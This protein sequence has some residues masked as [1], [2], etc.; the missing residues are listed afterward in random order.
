LK[1]GEIFGLLGPN[2]AG[3]TTLIRIINRIIEPE[4]GEIRYNGEL[5]K[6]KH[7]AEIGYLPEERGL[8][9]S[10]TVYDHAM[11]LGRLRR[12]SK[13]EVNRNLNH[14]LDKFDIASWKN[15]RIEELSKGMAQK[16]QFIC[17]V[18]HE[19]KLLILDEP[20]SG[21]DPV[22]VELIQNELQTMKKAGKTIMLSSH[23]MKSV[24]EICD[25]AALIHQSRKILEGSVQQI[26]EDRKNGRFAIKFKGNM[27]AFAN[28][29][30]TGFELVEK[31]ELG[32]NRFVAYVTM[33]G[34]SN[35]QDL[36]KTLLG[37]IEIEAAWEVLPSMQQIFIDLVT[38][39]EV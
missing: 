36:L 24:E 11:F 25:R 1:E 23:N 20:F 8:Y 26:R 19:P 27:L 2:G 37:Q 21:F 13:D 30:W 18:L 7:L 31:E 15:K 32:S 35:F 28:A 29:L 12:M 16:V 4:R 34:D 33:R 14:W 38:T 6:G 17:A 39:K 3:K 22:N 9:K 10:M 5:L